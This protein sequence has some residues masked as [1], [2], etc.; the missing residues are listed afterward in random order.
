M[1]NNNLGN[2][3]LAVLAGAALGAAAGMLLAPEKGS[4]LRRRIKDGISRE[5][6]HLLEKMDDLKNQITGKAREQR[7]DFEDS[8]NKFVEEAGDKTDDVIANLEK[9]LKELKAKAA[10]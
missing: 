1:A 3:L 10:R 2:G 6:D 8:F 5:S 7:H 9:K 4:K